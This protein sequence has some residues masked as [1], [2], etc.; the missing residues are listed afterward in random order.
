LARFPRLEHLDLRVEAASTD[1]PVLRSNGGGYLYTEAVQKQGYTNKGFIIGDP[2]GRESK[3]G[4]V[5]LT[6]HLSP[7]EDVQFSYRNAKAAKDFVPDGTTQ[8]LF[9]ISVVKRIHEDFELRGLVQYER[10]KA[11]VYKPELQ[12]STAVAFQVTWFAP[13]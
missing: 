2:V 11:P 13:R 7:R 5:W 6:Y 1:P 10:W 9:Q 4:Q 12:S 3:G 8:N